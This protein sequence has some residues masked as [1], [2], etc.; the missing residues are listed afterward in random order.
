MKAIILTVTQGCGHTATAAA[1]ENCL[2]ARG[3]EAQTIDVYKHINSFVSETVDKSTAL[4]TKI[5]PDLYRLVYSYL[6]EGV[7]IDQNNVFNFINKLC[8]YKFYRLVEEYDPDVI[9]CTHVFAAQLANQIKRKGRTRAKIVGIVTDYTI[10][11]YWETVSCVDYIIVASENLKY[12]A[13]KKGIPERKILPLGIPVHP[14]FLETLSKQ[15]ACK[16]LGISSEKPIIL[17][18]GGGLG[19]GID[20]DEI[21]KITSMRA[22]FEILIVCG[23]NKKQQRKFQKIKAESGS[24]NMHIYG[25]VNNVNEMM[26]AADFFI[27]K[28][29]GLSISEAMAKKL[30]LVVINPIA[31]HEERN[32]EFLMN[33]GAAVCATKTF[34]LDE[35]INLLLTSPTRLSLLQNAIAEI[36]KPNALN[37][38]CD[39][40]MSL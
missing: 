28:P 22:S 9:I 32:L 40:L 26:D 2:R 31:G 17:M 14:K 35:A 7:E 29:G 30:P 24:Q 18:M 23:Q 10:H 11:P 25:F 8:A 21:D 1:I 39:C 36:S 20:D 3:C 37:D 27:S 33:C 6:D 12:R 15:D 16:K 5:A 13:I 38:I 34:P 4:Y 19:Y